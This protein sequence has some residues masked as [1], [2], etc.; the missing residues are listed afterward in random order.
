MHNKF[1]FIYSA[2][3][4]TMLYSY[5]NIVEAQSQNPRLALNDTMQPIKILKTKLGTEIPVYSFEAFENNI[6]KS[7]EPSVTYV[8]NF[9]ATW[10]GPCVAELPYFFELEQQ[11]S[12]KNVKFIYVSLDFTKSLENKLLPFIETRKIKNKVIVLDQKNVNS[13]MGKIDTNWSG[14]IPATLIYN[15]EKRVFLEQNFESATDLE[16]AIKEF[17]P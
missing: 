8:I 13:W 5:S 15:S 16:N 11:Y 7:N 4:L 14:A 9:W 17:I 1:H 12:S 6:L 2:L 10:C 3:L